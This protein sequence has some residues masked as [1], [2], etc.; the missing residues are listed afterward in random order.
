VSDFALSGNTIDQCPLKVIALSIQ[1]S[2]NNT[3]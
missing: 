2:W 3:F 1:K